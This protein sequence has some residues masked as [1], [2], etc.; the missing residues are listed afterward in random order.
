MSQSQLLLGLLPFVVF[1]TASATVLPSRP[2]QNIWIEGRDEPS[3]PIEALESDIR[4]IGQETGEE[5][6]IAWFKGNAPG[7]APNYSMNLAR[8][9]RIGEQGYSSGIL[10]T[11]FA[12]SSVYYQVNPLTGETLSGRFDPIDPERF[13]RGWLHQ[14]YQTELTAAASPNEEYIQ[15]NTQSSPLRGV[16]LHLGFV[17]IFLSGYLIFVGTRRDVHFDSSGWRLVSRY[18]LGN[19]RNES[20]TGGVDGNW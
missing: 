3:A 19:P 2:L 16:K 15:S 1:Q 9:W 18:H 12:G 8:W 10:I 13:I 5:L 7:D 4:R 14:K 17:S 6:M 11:V 20:T